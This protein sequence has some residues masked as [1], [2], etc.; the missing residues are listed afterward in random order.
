MGITP[1]TVRCVVYHLTFLA[2]DFPKPHTFPMRSEFILLMMKNYIG[3]YYL[4]LLEILDGFIY[5]GLVHIVL[6]ESVPNGYTFF[7]ILD[8]WTSLYLQGYFY[9]PFFIVHS[10][11]MDIY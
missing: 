1:P 6:W 3:T 7:H 2:C 9:T 11:H 4:L 5:F 8:C 10:L